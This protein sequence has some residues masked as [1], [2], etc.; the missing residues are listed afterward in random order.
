MFSE[1]DKN[2]MRQR[3]TSLSLVAQQIKNFEKGFPFVRLVAAA[4][5]GQGILCV[6]ESAEADYVRTYTQLAGEKDIV[7]FVPASGAASRMFKALFAFMEASKTGVA[8]PENDEKWKA[9]SDFFKGLSSFAFYEQLKSV[10][11]ADG[12]LPEDGLKK[13]EYAK[14]LEYLLTK[15]GLNYGNLPKGL[16]AFHKYEEEVRTPVEEQMVEGAAYAKGKGDKVALHF[17]VSPEH[18]ALF[19]EKVNQLC[20]EYAH[21][22]AVNYDISFSAQ[23]ATT[24][25]LAVDLENRPFRNTDGSLLFRPAG[26]GALLENLNAIDADL[27]FIKNIDNVV[28]DRLKET[29]NRYKKMLGGILL[30]IQR[31]CFSLLDKL[32]T[33]SNENTLEAAAHFF[34]EMLGGDLP[35]DFRS[36]TNTQKTDWLANQLNRPLRLCGMVKNEGEPGG[37]PFRVENSRGEQSWQ[38]VEAAQIETHNQKQADI[39]AQATHFNPVDLVCAVRD[40]KGNKFNLLNYRDDETG[41]ITQKSKDG[42]LL[43]AQEL[44]GLWNGAMAGWNTCFVEVPIETFNPV[45]T[46]NDLLRKAHRC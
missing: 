41:F 37:G 35:K 34:T 32:E 44:P 5:A 10:A 29:S 36:R 7:K 38:I 46:I 25:T 15:K 30:Q 23:K 40:R 12:Y 14:V 26:H 1:K 9:V 43:K 22:H 4:T 27:I 16:L 24:D 11:A 31:K 17:T 33:Q 42:K 45:K 6:D 3:G 28:P 2:Q 18:D 20:P 8:S 19:K 39:L 13:G 21:R